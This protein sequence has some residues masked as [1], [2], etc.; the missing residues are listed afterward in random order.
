MISG[1]NASRSSTPRLQ[2]AD[3]LEH[4]GRTQEAR[5]AGQDR[6]LLRSARAHKVESI[7]KEMLAAQ[8]A[9]LRQACKPRGQDDRRLGPAAVL[10][11]STTG[12][13]AASRRSSSTATRRCSDE[14]LRSVDEERQAAGPPQPELARA[15]RPPT[16]RRSGSA[17]ERRTMEGDH[18]RLEELLPRPWLRQR[19]RW[20]SRGS[21][22]RGQAPRQE[23][24]EGRHLRA[25]RD[26]RQRGRAVPHGRAEVRRA[27]GAQGGLRPQLLQAAAGRRLRRL[28]VQEGLREAARRLRL[29][30][31]L[32]VDRPH[33]E[34]AR[35]RAAGWSTSR[36][37]GRG[38]AV[39]D[40]P[41]SA[42][43]ATT[44]RATR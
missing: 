16:P 22:T 6:H 41:A 25:A 30:R 19:S 27:D 34:D 2:A 29:A 20:D 24:E 42:S 37:D 31:L 33:P 32:P 10:H 35:P 17:G 9:P 14:K 12:R 3:H 15:A 11:R 21:P 39:P 23:P 5:G 7:I 36:S 18:S 40:R 43:R 28:E 13:G 4:R 26:P 1:A 44:R 38:Q 8:G